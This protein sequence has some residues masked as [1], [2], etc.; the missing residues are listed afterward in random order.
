MSVITSQITGVS[1]ICSTVCSGADYKKHQS[2][3]SLACFGGIHRW[4]VDSPH[5]ELVTLK[6][7]PFDDVTMVKIQSKNGLQGHL[8]DPYR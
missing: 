5:K 4:P 3:A 2:S 6:M 8:I 7:F 1:I